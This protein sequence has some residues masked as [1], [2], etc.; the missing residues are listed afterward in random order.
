MSAS[1]SRPVQTVAHVVRRLAIPVTATFSE[2]RDSYERA[3]PALDAARI[4]QLKR[5]QA[6]WDLVR[7]A[8]DENAPYSF[9]RYWGTDVGSLMALAAESRPCTEYL[10]GNHVF[11]QRM[12]RHDPAVMLYAPLRTA[13]YV[14]RDEHTWFAIDQP[15]T[16]FGSFHD[17]RIAQVGE[18][19]DAKLAALLEHL[20]LSVPAELVA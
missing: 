5:D 12:F 3:V 11:A 15:S 9:I 14:D 18:E 7:Q 20:G 19:L 6:S 10:M 16:R 2:F 1:D 8:T 13:I 17:P 4:E